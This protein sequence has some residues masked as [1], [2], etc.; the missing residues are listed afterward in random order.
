MKTLFVFFAAI[1]LIA[2]CTKSDFQSPANNSVSASETA[3]AT[4]VQ[5]RSAL[6]TAHTWMYK[7][8]YF[9]YTDQSHKGD[10][11]YVRGSSNNLVPLDDTRITFKSNGTFLETENGYSYPGIW[12]FTNSADTTFK[13]VF[14]YGTT[15][16]NTIVK[17]NNTQLNY[18]M[19]IGS[20]SHHN[21]AYTELITAK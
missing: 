17:L 7:S 11:Q 10:P 4:Q 14:N 5:N 6:I 21:F 9:H 13:M 8:F 12:Q 15:D 16:V 20:Y 1:I 3:L 18:T 19:P 2:A